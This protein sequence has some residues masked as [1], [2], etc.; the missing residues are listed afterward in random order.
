[1]F[2]GVWASQQQNH[3]G[4]VKAQSG[5]YLAKS[6]LGHDNIFKMRGEPSTQW[7]NLCTIFENLCHFTFKHFITSYDNIFI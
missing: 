7:T 4:L 3:T 5:Q 1:M 2:W 6:G